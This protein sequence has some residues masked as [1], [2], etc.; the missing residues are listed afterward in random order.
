MEIH[1]LVRNVKRSRSYHLSFSGMFSPWCLDS[2]SIFVESHDA[3]AWLERGTNTSSC[4][5][6]TI[7]IE[8]PLFRNTIG[9]WNF[10]FS[11]FAR[12]DPFIF[13]FLPAFCDLGRASWIACVLACLRASTVY[14]V[15]GS[16]WV[17]HSSASFR[18]MHV[19]L[20]ICQCVVDL[21]RWWIS[22]WHSMESISI[23]WAYRQHFH[24]PSRLAPR[25]RFTEDLEFIDL[26]V[27]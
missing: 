4:V 22:E 8:T 23:C 20:D 14:V 17:K 7:P 2:T 15:V 25:H 26:C 21:F 24:M 9:K 27:D 13:L 1:K 5:E 6:V 18:S 19:F 16:A 11:Q 12:Q 3:S 10:R